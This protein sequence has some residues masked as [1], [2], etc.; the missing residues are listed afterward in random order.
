MIKPWKKFL[1][2]TMK[3]NYIAEIGIS[4][5]LIICLILLSDLCSSWMPKGL[6]MII[7]ISLAFLF[8]LFVTLV[9]KEQ[10]RDEREYLHRYIA[11]R[12][13]YL[14]GVITLV[15][16]VVFQSFQYEVDPWMVITLGIMVLAKIAGL[17]YSRKR[18]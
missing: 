1:T 10:A 7:T 4:I 16:G 6:Y 8:L 15:V 11:S 18:H 12:F 5:L 13:A 2:I 9:W 14:S 17:M 3:D